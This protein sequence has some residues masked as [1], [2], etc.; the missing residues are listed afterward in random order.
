[1]AVYVLCH[2]AW[3]GGWYWQPVRDMLTSYSHWA[4]TPTYT[5][6]GERV[7]LAHPDLDL[8]TC[9][10]DVVNVILYEQLHDVV[11]VGHSFGGMVIT[12][13]ADRM[14]DRISHLVY[15]DAAVPD[16]GQSMA[17]LVH[18]EMNAQA[19][20]LVEQL[21][22]G[23]RLPYIPEPGKPADP[24]LVPFPMKMGTQPVTARNPDAL[25]LP[26]S[27][28]YCTEDKDALRDSHLIQAAQ[29]VRSDA[30]WDY[31]ELQTDHNPIANAT[32]EL[33]DLL[34]R[35]AGQTES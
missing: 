27:F 30:K 21:G 6:L 33:T 18:P 12:G 34:V 26:R 19:L 4:F 7:H 5:G 22:D 32:Q 1:M 23:W 15:V 28:I 8:D 16:D 31:Y 9:I 10:T 3:G 17:D 29:A 25:S 20:V 2:G 24:R 35:I 13:V 11:L 14:P